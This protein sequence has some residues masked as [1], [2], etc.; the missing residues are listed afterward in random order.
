MAI[1][2]IWKVK[3]GS[4]ILEAFDISLPKVVTSVYEGKGSPNSLDEITRIVAG[5]KHVE[6]GFSTFLKRLGSEGSLE[7]ISDIILS[8]G[9]KLTQEDSDSD[10]TNDTFIYTPIDLTD[11]QTLP[12]FELM[13]DTGY[14]IRIVDCV[15]KEMKIS[16]KAGE[17]AIITFSFVGA[18]DMESL[19][20]TVTGNYD[21]KDI[22]KVSSL[23]LGSDVPQNFE[24]FE[25]TITNTV[26]ERID[27][28]SE[29][30]ITGFI[31][32]KRN[33]EAS[34]D[35]ELANLY[36][37]EQVLTNF[38]MQAGTTDDKVIIKGNN[39]VV[40]E[41]ELGNR[42]DL[43]TSPLKLVFLPSLIGAND[44][45]EITFVKKL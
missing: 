24:T 25:L 43:I 45:I 38:S 9:F 39:V 1:R 8:A 7:P 21:N 20:G 33:I 5:K 10:G 40:K 2:N 32:T 14:Y 31:I 13:A 23:T 12:T 42:N 29:N 41:R 28:S 15:V 11:S 22:F 6:F 17:P 27:P 36:N 44:S 4:W 3:T 19:T 26:A 35:P 30:V 34:I 18:L 16:F 37:V